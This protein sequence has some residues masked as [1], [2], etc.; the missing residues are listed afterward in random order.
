MLLDAPHLPSDVL[1]QLWRADLDPSE[2]SGRDPDFIERYGLPI[3][4]WLSRTYFRAT[5]EGLDNLPD[6]PFI[7]V[8]VHSGAPLLPDVWPM[9]AIWWE[10]FSP[11]HPGYALVHD[12][13]FQIPLARNLLIKLGALRASP[14]N[15]ARV[16]EAGGTVLI[17][18]GGDLEAM[19]AFRSRHAVRFH[20]RTGVIRLALE[21]GVPLVPVV[22][23]GGH[24]VYVVLTSGRRLAEWTGVARLTRIKAVPVVA[25]LPWGI[26]LTGML[27]YLPLPARIDYKVGQPIA[28]PRAPELASD[29]ATLRQETGR[30]QDRMQ[31]MT[32]ELVDRR[33]RPVLG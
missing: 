30:L 2:L 8:A 17:F 21:H 24:E 4:R 11:R 32:W 15:A 3:C 13:A 26:W 1:D 25:G 12:A 33:R 16:L 31:Y 27:P 19:R 28:F 14:A 7:A 20:G 29:E 22:N 18:P 9:L 5:Y 23:V 6:P 10:R